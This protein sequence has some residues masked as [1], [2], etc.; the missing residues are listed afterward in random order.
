VRLPGEPDVLLAA[1]GI[2]DAAD[3]AG[4]SF[5]A[6]V[7]LDPRRIIGR[8]QSHQATGFGL[9][10]TSAEV[11]YIRLPLT[12]MEL[13][14]GYR[15]GATQ[16]TSLGEPVLCFD[17]RQ[18]SLRT[19]FSYEFDGTMA[20]RAVRINTG[21]EAVHKRLKDEGRITSVMGLAY[22]EDLKRGVRYWDGQ[23]WVSTPTRISGSAPVQAGALTIRD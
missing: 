13:A 19:G 6:I 18:E 14:T 21:T 9:P 8:T 15:G 7:I 10:T 1:S 12:D 20:V 11:Y 22:A 4:G 2:N 16:L 23:K 17:S 3:T 5:A